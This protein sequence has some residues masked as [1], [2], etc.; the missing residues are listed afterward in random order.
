MI[1]KIL[2]ISKKEI[3]KLNFSENYKILK[4]NHVEINENEAK[5]LIN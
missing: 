2:F 5:I 4:K 3:S 1:F